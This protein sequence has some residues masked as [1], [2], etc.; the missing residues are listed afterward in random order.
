MWEQ[1]IHDFHG[2]TPEQQYTKKEVEM[3]EE[4]QEIQQDNTGMVPL[5]RALIDI[6]NERMNKM[7]N[8]QL[9]TFLYGVRIVAKMHQAN[10][11]RKNHNPITNYFGTKETA[12]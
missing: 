6:E 12:N 10:R 7:N 1:R 8:N 11:R 5:A 9:E 3:I 2:E 4:L